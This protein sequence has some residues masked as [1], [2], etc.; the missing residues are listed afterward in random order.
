M[1]QYDI[2]IVNLNPT[3][4]SEI[5]KTRPCVII[6]PND[7]NEF[8]KTL[9][10]CPITS[11]SK[12]YPTRINFKLKGNKNSI[13]VDQIRTVDESRITKKIGKLN[14]KTIKKIKEVLKET[15]VD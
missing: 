14:K 7:I 12:N 11:T 6:S 10:V 9:I 4:G 13:A 3:R 8:L 2:V 1:K 15:L 5:K